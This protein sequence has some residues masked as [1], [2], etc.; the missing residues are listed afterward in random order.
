M[1]AVS[2]GTSVKTTITNSIRE[3]RQER[4][5]TQEELAQRCQVTRQTIIALEANRYAP[6]LELAFRLSHAL[7]TPI[8][9]I[10]HYTSEGQQ[11]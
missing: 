11:P 7:S 10:F 1:V 3:H 6:S 9:T 5:M 8:E 4:T 2:Q